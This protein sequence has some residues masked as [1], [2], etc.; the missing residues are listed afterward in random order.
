MGEDRRQR[1]TK[2]AVQQALM[3][4]MQDRDVTEISVTDLAQCADINRSTFYLH[5]KDAAD[6]LNGMQQEIVDGIT[7][8]IE[9]SDFD[10]LLDN[11]YPLLKTVCDELE[12]QPLLN[13]FLTGRGG[14]GMYVKIQQALSERLFQLYA[15][16]RADCDE[17][18]TRTVVLFVTGGVFSVFERWM[19][20]QT[21]PPLETVC[22][23]LSALISGGS[24][25]APKPAPAK[26]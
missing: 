26:T 20:L 23:T 1:K 8:L 6:V 24:K 2:T 19:S 15:A 25:N 7:E 13:R 21:R 17:E 4:L 16:R 9:E 10:A 22:E 5:Y 14:K 18:T 3:T 11:P 12:N